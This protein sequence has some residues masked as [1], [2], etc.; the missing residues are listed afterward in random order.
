[1]CDL[2]PGEKAVISPVLPVVTV[3]KNMYACKQL[4]QESISLLQD[5]DMTW[6]KILPRVDL[7][8][9][10]MIIERN[11]RDDSKRYIGVNTENVQQWLVRLFETHPGLQQ[12]K[13][14]NKLEFSHEALKKLDEVSTLQ[15]TLLICRQF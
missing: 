8:D 10:F 14:D 12:M 3:Q 1:M 6:A 2:T 13:Q 5:P 15:F 9:R 11:A 4:R 7:K